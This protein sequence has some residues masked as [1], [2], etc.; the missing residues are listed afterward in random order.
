MIRIMLEG[1]SGVET[2]A[3]KGPIKR[4]FE[5]IFESYLIYLPVEAYQ[6]YHNLHDV[7][8]W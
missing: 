4:I 8:L 7:F 3:D 5:S 1:E 6:C 2:I